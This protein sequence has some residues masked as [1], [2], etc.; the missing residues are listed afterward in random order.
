MQEGSKKKVVSFYI[1]GDDYYNG[2]DFLQREFESDE[3]L[4][5]FAEILKLEYPD[6]LYTVLI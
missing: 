2:R 4:M 5:V 3:E 1:N 6:L